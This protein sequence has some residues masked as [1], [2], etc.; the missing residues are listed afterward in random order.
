MGLVTSIRLRGD[1][2][3]QFHEKI[4]VIRDRIPTLFFPKHI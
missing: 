2:V 3:S 1:T 4:D